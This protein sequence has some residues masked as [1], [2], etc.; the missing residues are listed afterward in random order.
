ML[1]TEKQECSR[2][3][4]YRRGKP[5]CELRSR[6]LQ[7]RAEYPGGSS[8][9]SRCRNAESSQY[10]GAGDSGCQADRRGLDGVGRDDGGQSA[11][12]D[13]YAALGKE[14]AQAFDGAADAL[15]RGIVGCAEGLADVPQGLVLEIT[16]QDGSPV[17]RFERIHRF[18]EQRFHLR[19]IGERSSSWQSFPGRRVRAIDGAIPGARGQW[20][21]GARP[22]KATR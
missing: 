2:S 9:P 22:R 8:S 1:G 12:A 19:P 4:E 16:E 6:H 11:R 13:G 15:L 21:C 20:P 3:D 5:G 18:V 10:D 14:L 7:E 17:G